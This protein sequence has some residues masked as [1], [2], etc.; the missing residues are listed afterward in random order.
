MRR[1]D[2]RLAIWYPKYYCTGTVLSN[3]STALDILYS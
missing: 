2:I 1:T 3:T